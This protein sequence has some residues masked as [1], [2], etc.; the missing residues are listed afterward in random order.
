[1][2]DTASFYMAPS[3]LRYYVSYPYTGGCLAGSQCLD[4]QP[5]PEQPASQPANGAGRVCALPEVRRLRSG[6]GRFEQI[7]M[8]DCL[9]GKPVE[10]TLAAP[11]H[12]S[13]WPL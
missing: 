13:L 6:A 2:C 11:L 7:H 4:T 12:P 9:G 10:S 5:Q 1:M 3:I 8:M